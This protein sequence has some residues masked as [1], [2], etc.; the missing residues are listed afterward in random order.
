[1]DYLKNL[2]KLKEEKIVNDLDKK[3]LE[4]LKFL[5]EDD[6]LFFKLDLETALGILEFLEIPEDD[7]MRI[8]YELISPRTYANKPD[9]YVLQDKENVETL[10]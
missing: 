5:L 7:I 3:K 8:Y 1:M 6:L 9:E 10:K 2:L 4:N